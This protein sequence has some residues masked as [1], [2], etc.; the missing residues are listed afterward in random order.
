VHESI[1]GTRF[2][3]RVSGREPVADYEAILT[4]ISGSAWITGEH[5]FYVDDADPLKDGFKI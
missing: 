4:E 2:E 3:G 5:T 1:L